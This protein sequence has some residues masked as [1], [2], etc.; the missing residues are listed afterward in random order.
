MR[1]FCYLI[2]ILGADSPNLFHTRSQ[3]RGVS[4]AIGA[5]ESWRRVTTIPNILKVFNPHIVGGSVNVG[6]EFDRGTNLNLASPGATS[7][8][9]IQQSKRLIKVLSKSGDRYKWKLVTI[10]MGHNDVCTH[11]CN[12]TYTAFDA[13][14]R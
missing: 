14:P 8:E 1:I 6:G 11:P 7:R 12:T 13:S 9:L 2:L 5:L 10:L 3:Y 4:F